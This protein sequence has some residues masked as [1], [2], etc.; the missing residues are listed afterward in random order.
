MLL[1]IIIVRHMDSRVIIVTCSHDAL[2]RSDPGVF[3]F[4]HGRDCLIV[5]S[6]RKLVFQRCFVYSFCF[7]SRAAWR[8]DASYALLFRGRQQ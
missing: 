8:H 4:L 2:V 1:L 7:L 6:L 3:F 5:D